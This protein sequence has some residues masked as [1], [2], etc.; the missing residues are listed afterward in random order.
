MRRAIFMLG[1]LFALLC[2]GASGVAAYGYQGYR[3][4]WA[5]NPYHLTTQYISEPRTGLPNSAY[6]YPGAYA[7][8]W[9]WF[10]EYRAYTHAAYRDHDRL[11]LEYG[12][13][14]PRNPN[15]YHRGGYRGW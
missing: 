8:S 5:P 3:S 4:T 7:N 1:L 13:G 14:G 15:Y 2:V 10:G 12:Y 9:P 6:Y 11:I